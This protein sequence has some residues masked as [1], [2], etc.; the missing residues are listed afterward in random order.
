[1]T[2]SIFSAVHEV[3]DRSASSTWDYTATCSLT[4][5]YTTT[6]TFVIG[7]HPYIGIRTWFYTLPQK[8]IVEIGGLVL[9]ILGF[10]GERNANMRTN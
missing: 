3:V 1:M 9:S 8:V 2:C 7:P 4:W 6:C 10:R 5:D